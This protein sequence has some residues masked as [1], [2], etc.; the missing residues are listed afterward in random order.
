MDL[1]PGMITYFWLTPTRTGGFDVLCEQLCGMAHFAMR[2]RVVVDEPGAFQTWLSTQ[3]T[4]AQ[5]AARPAGDLAA[6]QALYAPCSACHGPRAQGNRALNAPK[7]SQQAPWYLAKQLQ[8][9]KQ[10]V[11]GSDDRDIYAKMMM[12][13]AATLADDTAIANVVAYI[14]SLPADAPPATLVGDPAR[15]KSLYAICASCHG[16]TGGGIWSTHAPRLARMSDWYLA[17]QL[18]NFRQ[19]IRG[20]HPQDF[21]G[22]QMSLMSKVLPDDQSVNDLLAYIQTFG[23]TLDEERVASAR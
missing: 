1:V 18:Q 22:A 17:R 10:G 19:G 13:M 7:L 9:F 6:G 12:P 2:G 15:G 14:R 11:R 8:N 3:P 23:H 5:T 21:Y 20:T 4:Y 16:A